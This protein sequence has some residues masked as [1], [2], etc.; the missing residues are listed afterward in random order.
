MQDLEA[1]G[2]SRAK[3]D[4]AL[5]NGRDAGV[6]GVDPD[7]PAAIKEEASWGRRFR[8]P[9][10]W[11]ISAILLAFVGGSIYLRWE[12]VRQ[13]PLVFQALPFVGGVAVLLGFYLLFFL[14]WR[15]LLSVLSRAP[16]GVGPLMLQRDFY[17]SLVARYLPAGKVLTL[18]A[19]IELFGRAGGSRSLAAQAL[20]L[21]QI[22]LIGGAAILAF[23]AVAFLPLKEVV[24]EI[25]FVSQ[26]AILAGLGVFLLL[27]LFPTRLLP[28]AG[29]FFK[30]GGR[31]G[32]SPPMSP[33]HL[34]EF[35]GRFLAIN[36][37]H[38]AGAALILWAF[39]PATALRPGEILWVIV[40]YPL[41]RVVGQLAV[42]LPGGLGVRE[43][44][45]AFVLGGFLPL[46]PLLVAGG[47][48]RLVSIALEAG[49]WLVS[50]LLLRLRG[51]KAAA[52]TAREPDLS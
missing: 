41:S 36:L 23:A 2:G 47:M 24:P 6:S 12:E 45:F 3:D 29:R 25:P 20:F 4:T 44:A 49:L 7:H 11:I 37:L 5:V 30:L 28:I 27:F 32:E 10:Q 48:I 18:G 50:V 43:G 22:Q 51:S 40:A 26:L 1:P 39:L 13:T 34:L 14:T 52:S 8:N 38:G 35:T 17:T 31:I 9:L 42:V 33:G 19:R 21:E 46:Q 15:R 16:T